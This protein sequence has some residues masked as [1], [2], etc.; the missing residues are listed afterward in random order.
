MSSAFGSFLRGDRPRPNPRAPAPY[1]LE[2]ARDNPGFPPGRPR[3]V[4]AFGV[5]VLPP[6]SWPRVGLAPGG[7][8]R[9][10]LRP[11]VP[12]FTVQTH[13][14]QSTVDELV[15]RLRAGET[16][17][18]V[19]VVLVDGRHW[20]FDGHHALAAYR[21]L[22]RAI[23]VALYAPGGASLLPAPRLADG[24]RPAATREV[25]L[26]NPGH[27]G[28]R[29]HPMVRVLRRASVAWVSRGTE[30]APG[31]RLRFGRSPS[32]ASQ[33]GIGLSVS[34]HPSV[35]ASLARLP[36]PIYDL[37]HADGTDG[38]FVRVEPPVLAQALTW[39]VAQGWVVPV[40]VWAWDYSD[41]DG[42]ERTKVFSSLAEATED[43]HDPD[44]LRPVTA[45]EATPALVARWSDYFTGHRIGEVLDLVYAAQEAANL[46]LATVHPDVDGWWWDDELA[47]E[48]QS[49]PR[50][51][52]LP[53]ALP[54]WKVAR[55]RTP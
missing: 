42:E 45:P 29:G 22:G 49:A 32:A 3:P 41:D 2:W 34:R 48:I 50:G 52:I 17:K 6:S 15:R 13:V 4:S 18:P 40:E 11:E 28:L 16:L 14:W 21:T 53:H 38:R 31:T 8:R 27:G 30:L 37:V 36:G 55:R 35:W 44:D 24:R 12:L 54:R 26:D 25:V 5:T 39:A 33:E 7:G 43:G 10:L 46:W 51:V 47:P 23:P 1:V 9:A 20:V 19:D